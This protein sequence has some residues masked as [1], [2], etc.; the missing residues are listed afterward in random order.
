MTADAATS[1]Q[2]SSWGMHLAAESRR[3]QG[4]TMA[5]TDEQ[6][7]ARL[8]VLCTRPLPPKP[9]KTPSVAGM[10]QACQTSSTRRGE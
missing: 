3:R 4:L 1:P 8:R 9:P 10:A 6:V 2:D 5:V 7:T